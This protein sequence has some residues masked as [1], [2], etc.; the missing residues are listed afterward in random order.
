MPQKRPNWDQE[1]RERRAREH[2]RERA[3]IDV[4]AEQDLEAVV[5]ARRRAEEELFHTLVEPARRIAVGKNPARSKAAR[6]RFHA[7]K[8]RLVEAAIEEAAAQ[9]PTPELARRIQQWWPRM[10]KRK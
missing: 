5:D 6:A 10:L 7:K 8:V 3:V 2:G 4:T 1:G 9:A